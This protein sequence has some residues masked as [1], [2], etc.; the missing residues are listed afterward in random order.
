LSS[1]NIAQRFNQNG[2]VEH[3][4]FGKLKTFQKFKTLLSSPFVKAKLIAILVVL[5][6]FVLLITIGACS[7]ATRYAWDVRLPKD[8]PVKG[9]SL[10]NTVDIINA[11]VRESTA[12]RIPKV[13]ILDVGPVTV[14]KVCVDQD[15][16]SNMDVLIERYHTEMAP[17]IAKGAEGYETCP[18]WENFPLRYRLS[19]ASITLAMECG[20]DFEYRQDG[21]I[22][23]NPR[24]LLECRAYK[25]SD[26]LLKLVEE[27]QKAGQIYHAFKPVPIIFAQESSMTWS[28]MVN[29][30][31]NQFRGEEALD[32]VTLYLP[33]RKCILVIESAQG[34]KRIQEN[35]KAKGLW[36]E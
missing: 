4:I 17:I 28:F 19:D 3:E 11:A 24:K 9:T 34:H 32:A 8:L 33:D 36:Q 22:L 30:G 2:A 5:I 26:A 1:S 15:L 12:G 27:R 23:K 18:V 10:S 20:M 16:N 7:H 21:V 31:P 29:D 13:I 25:V 35:L 14:A 6:G